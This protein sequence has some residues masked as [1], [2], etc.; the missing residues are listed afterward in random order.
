MKEA[1][2]DG[3]PHNTLP[4]T[5]RRAVSRTLPVQTEA[6]SRWKHRNQTLEL[7]SKPRGLPYGPVD[8]RSWRRYQSYLGRL[9]PVARADFYRRLMESRGLK[10]IRA[11]AKVTGEDWSRVARMLKLLELPEPVLEFL[12][13]HDSLEISGA[14]TERQL[15]ELLALKDHR[16]IWYRFQEMLAGLEP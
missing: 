1:G 14:F 8:G 10:S 6:F 16:R 12:R 2:G 7:T 3:V 4:E 5:S 9:R 15:R 11:L 13:T